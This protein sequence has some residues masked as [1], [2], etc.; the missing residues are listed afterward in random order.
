MIVMAILAGSIIFAIGLSSLSASNAKKILLL[1]VLVLF[2]LEYLPASIPT[3]SI[4]APQYIYA[5]K[6]SPEDGGVIDLISSE[7]YAMYYQTIHE[8]PI[9][10]GLISRT[11]KSVHEKDAVLMQLIQ[12]HEYS[13]LHDYYGIRYLIADAKMEVHSDRLP[14]RLLF[15]DGKVKLYEFGA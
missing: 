3:T 15:S 11:P 13:T 7:P 9:V 12:N 5:L 8:K 10:L 14:I 2:F 6:D 4:K 1:A